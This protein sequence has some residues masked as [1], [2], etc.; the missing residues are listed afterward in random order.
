ME[1]LTYFKDIYGNY[2][3]DILDINTFLPL[4]QAFKKCLVKRRVSCIFIFPFLSPVSMGLSN[5]FT[6]FLKKK[7]QK[8]YKQFGSNKSNSNY[9]HL[10]HPHLHLHHLRHRLH[11]GMRLLIQSRPRSHRL[12]RT[13]LWLHHRRHRIC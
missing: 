10:H 5:I 12:L 4:H 2:Y 6:P 13:P 8:K 3:Q 7:L 9:H 11:I 1:N